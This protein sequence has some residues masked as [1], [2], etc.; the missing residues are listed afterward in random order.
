MSLPVAGCGFAKNLSATG[1]V[2]SATSP[3]CQLLGWYT[4]STA[5]GTLVLRKDGSGGAVISGTITPAIGWHPFPADVSGTL[6][7]TIAVAAL[8]VTF[9]FSNAN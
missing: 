4:N 6:H 3:G 7:A 9:F 1:N 8:D 2:N 5:G